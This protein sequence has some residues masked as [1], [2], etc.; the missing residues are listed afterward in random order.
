MYPASNNTGRLMSRN[1]AITPS[2]THALRTRPSPRVRFALVSHWSAERRRSQRMLLTNCTCV[3][4][5]SL[6]CLRHGPV[7]VV[8][9][10]GEIARAV[11][12]GNHERRSVDRMIVIKRFQEMGDSWRGDIRLQVIDTAKL[13][14]SRMR[15]SLCLSFIMLLHTP[16]LLLLEVILCG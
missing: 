3:R 12:D 5:P 9:G 15:S 4:G 14:R 1:A 16:R 7:S 13:L 2:P 11:G 10:E 8:A 6:G